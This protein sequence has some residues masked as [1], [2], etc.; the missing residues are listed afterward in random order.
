MEQED[1]AKIDRCVDKMV[2][3]INMESLWPQLFDNNIFNRDDVNVPK[4]KD[5]LDQAETKRDILRTIKTRGPRAYQNFLKCLRKT[6]QEHIINILENPESIFINS[7]AIRTAS[8]TSTGYN[9]NIIIDDPDDELVYNPAEA[10][11]RL[12]IIVRKSREFF[13]PYGSEDHWPMKSNP[14]GLALIITLINYVDTDRDRSGGIID[15]ENLISLY[16]QMGFEVHDRKDLTADEISDEV[17]KF[18]Q[19]KKLRTVDSCFVIISG[20]GDSTENGESLIQGVDHTGVASTQHREIKCDKIVNYFSAENC[21][22][23][24]GKPKIFIFQ[25]CRGKNKQKALTHQD[26]RQTNDNF[27]LEPSIKHHEGNR[28][29]RVLEK[30][31]R[32]YSDI[33][34]VHSTLP[35]YVSFRDSKYGSWFIQILC[36]VFM[37]RAYRSHVFELLQ[38]VDKRLDAI[39]TTD[40]HCQTAL[41][42]VIGFHKKMYINPGLF[43]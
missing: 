32:N 27:S 35:N 24:A 30:S 14:R 16:T 3:I 28:G 34:I 23:L 11:E 39:R 5:K 38:T 33:L 26:A 9:N 31:V 15:H 7:T 21:P 10:K 40:F 2:P 43:E 19:L 41:I 36:E 6:H 20:H 37:K 1:R 25:A 22:N 18:S 17:K 12:K 13:D 4:W 42:E 29:I 8:S